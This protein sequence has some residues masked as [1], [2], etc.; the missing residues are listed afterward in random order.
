MGTWGTGPF[1]SDSAADFAGDVRGC[2][3]PQARNDLL[4]ITIRAGIERLETV[5]LDNV[6]SWGFELE[7]AIAA[8]AFVADEYTGKKEF[9]DCSFARGVDDDMEL[10]PYVEFLS[11]RGDLVAASR[12]FLS[13]LLVCMRRDGVDQEW[14]DPIRLLRIAVNVG[15]VV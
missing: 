7:Q 8:T 3:D 5:R 9:T 4:L 13:Q 2:S 6:Y 14:L 11:V 10:K 1:D 15:E 12:Q